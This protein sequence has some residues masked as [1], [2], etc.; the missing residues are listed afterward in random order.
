MWGLNK[1]CFTVLKKTLRNSIKIVFILTIFLTNTSCDT[2]LYRVNEYAAPIG[3]LTVNQNVKSSFVYEYSDSIRKKMD[4]FEIPVRLER[5]IKGVEYSSMSRY[6]KTRMFYINNGSEMIL[7]L[8][9]EI[10]H[11]LI[12]IYWPDKDTIHWLNGSDVNEKI[13]TD[14]YRLIE[15]NYNAIVDSLVNMAKRDSLTDSYIFLK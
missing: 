3:T 10:N 7:Y 11:N 15:Q 13:D 5:K 6:K 9:Y 4:F 14:S 1:I 8:D 12:N 2:G